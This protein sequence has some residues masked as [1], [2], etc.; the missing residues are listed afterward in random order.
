HARRIVDVHLAAI[1][2][3]VEPLG[4]AVSFRFVHRHACAPAIA[5]AASAVV[6]AAVPACGERASRSRPDSA[7]ATPPAMIFWQCAASALRDTKALAST[8]AWNST[9][10]VAMPRPSCV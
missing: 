1:G 6:A 3:D 4:H 7:L 9:L 8:G 2:L 5:P 10:T